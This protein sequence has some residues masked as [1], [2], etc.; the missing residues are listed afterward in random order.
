[1]L[2][3][4]FW[5]CPEVQHSCHSSVSS[6]KWN[7]QQR[8]LDVSLSICITYETAFHKWKLNFV[9]FVIAIMEAKA[10]I[11]CPS[12]TP[13]VSDSFSLSG[14][15]VIKPTK[16]SECYRNVNWWLVGWQY[17]VWIANRHMSCGNSDWKYGRCKLLSSY[18]SF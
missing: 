10:E 18:Q 16:C 2:N 4:W 1:M 9:I 14:I 15:V 5:A 13:Q 3:I 6:P 12:S 11:S 7:L 8:Y 17:C